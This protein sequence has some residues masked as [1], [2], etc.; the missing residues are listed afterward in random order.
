MVVATQDGSIEGFLQSPDQVEGSESGRLHR[1]GLYCG[2]VGS[3]RLVPRGVAL[4]GFLLSA[5]NK[6]KYSLQFESGV[7][8]T[9]IA[10]ARTGS[11]SVRRRMRD[12]GAVVV[13]VVKKLCAS[14]GAHWFQRRKLA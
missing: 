10:T 12:G 3:G 9:T 11:A 4:M 2:V 6:C 1:A 5:R 7:T 13:V 14:D 8:E